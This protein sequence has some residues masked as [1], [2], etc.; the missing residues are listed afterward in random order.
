MAN[1]ETKVLKNNTL[2]EWRQK[3]NEVSHELGDVSLLDARLTDKQFNFTGNGTQFL[4]GATADNNSKDLQIQLKPE[5]VIDAPATIIMTGN[6]TIPASFVSGKVL[7]QGSSG[8]ESFTG[9]INYINKNKI[10]LKNTTGTFDASL[11]IKFSTDSIASTK[12]VRLVTESYKVGYAKATQNNV[13]ANQSLVQDGFHIVN[14]SLEVTLT[15]SPSIP[16]SFTEGAVVTQANGFSGVLLEAN[17]SALRFKSHSGTFSTTAFAGIPHTD[18]ANRIA[19]ANLSSAAIQDVSVGN[20]VEY[21]T[22]PANSHAVVIDTQNA[23]DSITEIQDDIG[24]IAS[25][26]TTNKSDIVSSINEIETAVRGTTGNYTLSTNSGD[27]VGAINEHETDIGNMTFTGLSAT[28][29]SAA[30]RE[31]RTELGNH[32]SLGT[33]HT[34]DAI[35]AINELE[36]AIRGSAGNY[37]IGTDANDLVAAINEIETVLRAGNPNYTLSTNAQNVRDAINE[38]ET[39]IGNMTFTGLSATDISAAIRELRTE[40]GDHATI[41][42][43][44]GYSATNASAGIVEIQG[45]LGNYNNLT[46]SATNVTLAINELDLK[47]GSATLGT[48]AT[49]LSGAVNEFENVLRGTNTNYT[50]GTTATNVRDAI[51]EL[52]TASRGANTNYTLTTTAQN[53]RDAI[54]EHETQ[55]NTLDTNHLNRN[56]AAGVNQDVNGSITF[57]G[58][59]VDFSNTT[60]LFSAAGGV[61][62]FGSAFVNLNATAAAGSNVNVQGLQVDRTA[63]SGSNPKH[64][65]RLIWNETLVASKPARA[66][67]LRGMADDKSDNTADIVT[68][69]NAEDLIQNNSESG[70]NVTWDSTNQNFDFNVNDPTLTFTG[71]VTGSGTLTNLGNLSIA[72]TVQPNSVALGTDTTGNYVAGISGTNNQITVSGSGSETSSVTLSLPSDVAISGEM[73]AGSL[74]INGAADISGNTSIGGT[75]SVAGNTT[76]GNASSDTVSVPGNLTITGDLTVNG[77]NTVLNTS[78]LEVEDIL[79]LTGSTATTL[80]TTGGFGLETKLFSGRANQTINSRTWDSNGKHP[81]PASNVTGSHSIVFNFGYDPGGGNPKGRWEMDG[82]PLLS[83]AT[84]GSPNI[85]GAN[86]EQGDNL[87]FVAGTGMTLVTGKSGTVHTVTYTNDDKGSSQYIFKNVS[88]DSGTNAV[89]DS[90]DDTLQIL[91]GT[92][93]ASVGDASNDRIT[94]NHSDVGAGAAHYGPASEDGQYIRRIQVNDQGHVI[95]VTVD[96]FDDRY[97]QESET[98]TTNTANNV[99]RRDSNGHVFATEFNGALDGNASTATTLQTTRQIGGTNFNGSANIDIAE[100]IV[101][102]DN[103]D[104]TFRRLIFHKG[105]G[106]GV[107]SL[108]HDDG[109]TYRASDNTI[110]AT[111]FAGTADVASTLTVN[112]SESNSNYGFLGAEGTGARSIYMDQGNIYFNPSTNTITAANFAGTATNVVIN[113]SDSN[114]NYPIVWRSGNTAYYT[115]EVTLNPGTN[116]ITASQF[117]GS[118]NGNASSATTV[119]VTP[120]GSNQNYRMAF[121]NPNETA[122]NGSIYKD[123]AANF[124]YNPHT[125]TLTVPNISISGSGSGTFANATNADTVDSLHASSF[126]RSDAN[127]TQTG[128]I[129]FGASGAN[130]VAYKALNYGSGMYGVYSASRFQHVWGMGPGYDMNYAGD[131]LSNFYGLAY[132]HSNNTIDDASGRSANDSLTWGSG[133]QLLNV[134]NGSVTSAMGSSIWT[135]G[136][137]LTTSHGNSAN[138]KTAYD[139]TNAATNSNTGNAIVKRASDGSFSAGTITASLSGNASTCTK[140]FVN[141][142]NGGTTMRILGSHDGISSYGNVYSTSS[143]YIN[144]SSN[145]VYATTFHGALS[146]NASTA[147]SATTSGQVTINYNNNSNSTYQML[148]GS[149]NYVYGTAGIYCQPYTDTIYATGDVVASASDD[150]LKD[151]KGN[152]ENALEKVNALNGFYYN[153][154]DKA[155]E[156][157]FKKEEQKEEE[158]IGLSAQDVQKVAP[159]LVT[160]SSLEGYDT[161]RYDKVTALLVEAIKELTEQNKELKA[162]IE[163]LKSIN[164]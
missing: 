85:E 36:T 121:T 99:V 109:L 6:P 149:G 154:N 123:S 108:F 100:I 83:A 110:S 82:S 62:N 114:A 1:N 80:P 61:A 147:S 136:N 30:L 37:T 112:D 157:G 87:N 41:D 69:Y 43:A 33:T 9:I 47:Q 93:L 19:A 151:K 90:N 26:G 111:R 94:I 107:K 50:L 11:P 122:G 18:N 129:S 142:Y 117:N 39:D 96:D 14:F 58:D 134:Q 155:V 95:S 32:A 42:D 27:L 3:T 38:H 105:D 164:S 66:W 141:N 65:V 13:I 17:T 118:L 116:Q 71:D 40:L 146:G 7:F 131:G 162:E 139:A 120:T 144:M 44:T 57:K 59:S 160:E 124:Y 159:E 125:N 45:A 35:G 128:T 56:L 64:D 143:V 81:N 103:S 55:I 25:L 70:I 79:I 97:V 28:D 126:L 54:N 77:T 8:S 101:T 29:I 133:H 148:W 102:E 24:E 21:H 86:F 113:H 53:F 104:N 15:G 153:W 49:T 98:S 68:F 135:S 132:T 161:V 130:Q 52:E 4:F 88:A 78:T 16:A 63:L 156:L 74:D 138:W 23:I 137:V 34:S 60:A 140:P 73:E 5:E 127:D 12:L 163:S 89:A 158:H 22:I 31:L 2:E 106:T 145:A 76:L 51:N 72:L 119:Y 10:S 84:L 75:L 92:A 152:I 46:T 150:R 48:N 91:G 115:D 20:I 67:Q